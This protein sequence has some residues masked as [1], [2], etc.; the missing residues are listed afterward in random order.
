M[1]D[2]RKAARRAAARYGV[3]P[4]I[5]ERQIGAESGFNK[6]ARSPAGA[7][8]IAQFMPGTAAS[9]GV[10]LN[11]GRAQDDLDGAARHMSDLLKQF[12]GNYRLALAGYN[13][14]AGA[15]KKALTQ[16][17]ET[18]NYVAKILGGTDPSAKASPAPRSNGA[19]RDPL[20]P[21]FETTTTPGVDNSQARQA[22]KLGYLQQRNNPDALLNLAAGLRDAQDVPGTSTTKAIRGPQTGAQGASGASSSQG[23]TS[24]KRYDVLELFWNGPGAVNVKNGKRVPKGFVSGHTEHVHVASG[25]KQAIEIGRLAQRM[26]LTVREN[27]AFDKVDPV[28]TDGSYHYR[29][30]AI[31]VSGDPALLAKFA[32]TVAGRRK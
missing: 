20:L 32:R 8:G 27:P 31:D 26:G 11:D 15:A 17:P 6:N 5:F 23:A 24:A 19:S 22:L 14:G 12:N 13:A 18:R 1:P 10:N 28:H 4:D 16:Y 29:N 7:S 30:Q 3:N 21:E 2:Y 25:P 9:Y